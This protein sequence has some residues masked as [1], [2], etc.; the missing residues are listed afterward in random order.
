MYQ[1]LK[2][3]ALAPLLIKAQQNIFSAFSGQNTTLKKGSGSDFFELREYTTGDDI[4]HIDWIISSKMGLLY[5]KIFHEQKEKSIVLVS[6][7][8]SS[9][10]FGVKKLKFDIFKE[11]LALLSFSCI[12]QEDPYEAYAFSQDLEFATKRT[13]EIFSVRDM[14]ERLDTT[15]LFKKSINYKKLSD[16]LFKR[17]R[18]PSLIFLIGDFLNS[19]ELNINLLASKHEV[20]V[21]I[22]RDRFEE[23]P[24]ALGEINITDPQTA[25]SAVINLD[26]KAAL[27]LKAKQLEEDTKLFLALNQNGVKYLKIYTDEEPFTKLLPFMS[28][29]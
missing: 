6:L 10:N 14:I 27:T 21:I 4:K 2:K 3:S 26:K 29:R 18:E 28:S 22:I 24:I 7:L 8:S 11:T 5:V 17:V 20:L 19:E 15:P 12:K 25:Q 23:E 16:S 9:L 1:Y 13:K